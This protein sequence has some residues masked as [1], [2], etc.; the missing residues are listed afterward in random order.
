MPCTPTVREAVNRTAT[1]DPFCSQADRSSRVLRAVHT[2]T[3]TVTLHL[4][5]HMRLGLPKWGDHFDHPSVGEEEVSDTIRL[6]RDFPNEPS[7]EVR[8]KIIEHV[9]SLASV[10]EQTGTRTNA[11]TYHAG[12]QL[13]RCLGCHMLHLATQRGNWRSLPS[14]LPPRSH[15]FRHSPMWNPFRRTSKARTP[16]IDEEHLELRRAIERCDA[17]K[18]AHDA[19]SLDLKDVVAALKRS[20]F[21]DKVIRKAVEECMGKEVPASM[22]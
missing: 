11:S 13:S 18:V 1:F 16:D 15:N 12:L 4:G 14:I 10:K 6:F 20:S 5:P 9:P 2:I 17:L 8:E 3:M 19:G 21:S 22:L 7:A